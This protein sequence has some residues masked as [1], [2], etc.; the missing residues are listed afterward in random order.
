MRSMIDP[1]SHE[2]PGL[3]DERS[4]PDFR[5]VFGRLLG[6]STQADV[7]LQRIRLSALD[8]DP[9]ELGGL[10]RLRVL[11]A[12]VS[13]MSLRVEAHGLLLEPRRGGTLR[14]LSGLLDRGVVQVR[15]APLGGWS[16]DYTVFRADEHPRAVLLGLHWL[17]RP[18]PH[19]GPALASLHGP[20]GAAL[21]ARRFEES[22]SR[23]HD[24]RP[25]IQGILRQACGTAP[26]FS[27][28][29]AKGQG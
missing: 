6:D 1:Y 21:A 3:F 5:T 20:T 22:W 15:S 18:F 2:A 14:H 28:D 26:T 19:R 7:A 25:A 17:E 9:D 13:A 11:L 27:D 10:Q 8:L 29:R 24:I 12:Q 23:A 16:P 4:N